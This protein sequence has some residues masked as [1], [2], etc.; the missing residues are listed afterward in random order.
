MTV[1][2]SL[3]QIIVDVL[4]NISFEAIYRYFHTLS[5]LGYKSYEDVYKLILLLYLEE[6][7]TGEMSYY[8]NEEDL[9]II[10]EALTCLYG[11][12]CLIDYP[13]IPKD[14]SL[15][16][17]IRD[18]ITLRISEDCIL[19]NSEYSKTRIKE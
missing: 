5:V 6:L 12:T 10:T 14:D 8:I 3:N 15:I 1:T 16:H 17:P 11:S 2:L 7:L 4:T 18:R 13:C 9:R 19:R